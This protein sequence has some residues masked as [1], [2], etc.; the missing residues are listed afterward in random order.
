MT[1]ISSRR[2]LGSWMH[3][4]G[5][6]AC[7]PV[8]HIIIPVI[9]LCLRA[10][11]CHPVAPFRLP[12]TLDYDVLLCPPPPVVHLDEEVAA[13]EAARRS[14]EMAAMAEAGVPTRLNLWGQ[15]EVFWAG[16][17]PLQAHEVGVGSRGL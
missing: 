12:C 15:E 17:S 13:L 11:T 4:P 6:L 16:I 1:R 5:Y 10:T 2:V 8:H 14:V 3:H 9:C 7:M